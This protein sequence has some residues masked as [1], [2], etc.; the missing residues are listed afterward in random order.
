MS[1]NFGL[2]LGFRRVGNGGGGGGGAGSSFT[3][4]FSGSASDPS[5]DAANWTEL[6]RLGAS[7]GVNVGGVTAA[8]TTR[9]SA[10]AFGHFAGYVTAQFENGTSEVIKYDCRTLGGASTTAIDL[11]VKHTAKTC[12][13]ANNEDGI[14]TF[15]GYNIQLIDEGNGAVSTVTRFVAGVGSQAN[16]TNN[17]FTATGLITDGNYDA[18]EVDV[19]VNA[20]VNVTITVKVNGSTVTTAVDTDAA[21]VTAKGYTG[22]GVKCALG[23]GDNVRIDNFQINP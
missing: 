22:F 4:L 13:K 12:T 19:V 7:T 2:G 17:T 15:S 10:G 20:G 11:F 1:L 21:R 16:I 18:V 8:Q 9:V 5:L 6:T 23:A 14:L 3:E